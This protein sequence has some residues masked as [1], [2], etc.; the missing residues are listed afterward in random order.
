MGCCSRLTHEAVC[1]TGV[2]PKSLGEQLAVNIAKHS[3]GTLILAS[4]TK[5]KLETVAETIQHQSPDVKPSLVVLDLASMQAVRSAAAEISQSVDRMDILINNAGVTSSERKETKDGL[6][7][8]FGA[9]HIG[10]FLFTSLLSPLLIAGAARVVNVSSMGYRLSPIRFNDYNFEGKEVPPEQR[11]SSK[12]PA[13]MSVGEHQQ[14]AGFVAYA[15]SKTANILH[16][17]SLN[18]KLGSKGVKAFAVHPGSTWPVPDSLAR[19]L[20]F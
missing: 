3:P 15:Q 17:V 10:H 6:E 18:Q 5:A 2:S 19:V 8:T 11:P 1:I 12:L 14:Y 16:A 13:H 20:T 9:N 4:R 7:Q